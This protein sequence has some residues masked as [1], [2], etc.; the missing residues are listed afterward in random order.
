MGECALPVSNR[1]CL[2]ACIVRC[3]G[4]D[5]SKGFYSGLFVVVPF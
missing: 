4:V 1:V 5:D 2:V 3:I